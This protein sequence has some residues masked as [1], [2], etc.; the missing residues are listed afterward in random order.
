MLSRPDGSDGP[1]KGCTFPL[2]DDGT[3]ERITCSEYVYAVMTALN[4]T[5]ARQRSASERSPVTVDQVVQTGTEYVTTDSNAG[6]MRATGNG[7][8]TPELT[9]EPM[10]LT[11]SLSEQLE[12]PIPH[13]EGPLLIDDMEAPDA[14]AQ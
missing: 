10:V 5:Q 13:V 2:R 1:K 6:D 4:T 14:R 11:R 3:E 9:E 8:L 7:E 12:T